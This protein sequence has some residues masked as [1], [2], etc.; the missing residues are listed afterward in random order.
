MRL[1]K[2]IH[3]RFYHQKTEHW[4]DMDELHEVLHSLPNY[5]KALTFELLEKP[6]SRQA[7]RESLRHLEMRM[8][9]HHRREFENL[10]ILLS[11]IELSRELVKQGEEPTHVSH[12]MRR[13]QERIRANIII[14][15]LSEQL[16]ETPLNQEQL[17]ERFAEQ[18]CE[19]SPKIL[20]LSGMGYRPESS[21]DLP[22]YLDHFVRGKKLVLRD[23]VYMLSTTE[24]YESIE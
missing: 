20:V 2:I 9:R 6:M 24:L 14:D 8:G 21:A 4:K 15:W 23:G 22:R 18:F 1:D 7:L 11:A 19:Q 16:K 12:F 5:F 3:T 17:Q 10:L 13:A